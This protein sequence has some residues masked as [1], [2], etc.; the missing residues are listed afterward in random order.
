MNSEICPDCSSNELTAIGPCQTP[1]ELKNQHANLATVVVQKMEKSVLYSC[2]ACGLVF[3]F[4]RLNSV[5]LE[6][7]YRNL[8][9]SLWQDG[10]EATEARSKANSY[11]L[12]RF[13]KSSEISVLDV[14]AYTGGFLKSLPGSWRKSAIEPSHEAAELLES[15]GVKLIGHFLHEE[16]LQ[17]HN[18]EFD[19]V[20]MIDVLEHVESPLDAINRLAAL[21]KPGGLILISTGNSGHWTWRLL[22]GDHWYL[23]SIQHCSFGSRRYLR[24]LAKLTNLRITKQVAHSHKSSSSKRRFQQACEVVYSW[25]RSRTGFARRAVGWMVYWPGL[26]YLKHKQSTPFS[27]GLRDHLFVVYEKGVTG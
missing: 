10:G 15:Q 2:E 4:P 23:H 21:V 24:R 9:S 12:A 11:L 1:A 5:E 27:D 8:P 19:V 6:S 17:Q 18:G 22:K 20:S 3:R 25:A 16:Q 14:G 13:A 7:F 26:D